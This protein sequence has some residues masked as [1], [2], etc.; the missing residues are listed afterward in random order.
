MTKPLEEE[1]EEEEEG[2]KKIKSEKYIGR[3]EREKEV[4][5]K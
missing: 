5:R 3:R 2:K 1:E 4:R